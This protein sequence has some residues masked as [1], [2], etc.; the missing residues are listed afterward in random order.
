[1]CSELVDYNMRDF[2]PDNRRD[3]FEDCVVQCAPAVRNRIAILNVP[4]NTIRRGL[5]IAVTDPGFVGQIKLLIGD[6]SGR[7][8]IEA[9]GPIVLD[10]RLWRAVDV[11]IAKR[12]TIN[13]ARVV[14]DNATLRVGED[15]LWSDEI[16]IQTN[17]QHG[18]IDLE[19]GEVINA[20]LRH[21]TIEPHVWIGRRVIV[22]PDTTIGKGAI[23]GA[24]SVVTNNVLAETV[25]VGVPAKQVRDKVSWSR[26]PE[27]LSQQEMSFFDA[28]WS[29]GATSQ[30]LTDTREVG[31]CSK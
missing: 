28:E 18:V 2:V 16:L 19:T 8:R 1:M 29:G 6:C 10:L 5:H 22:M 3:Q 13:Q 24:G 30:A 7:V 25:F 12:V 21:I 26:S 9:R 4:G 14:C 20:G 27:G 11:E 31:E 23:V 17:D 15:G